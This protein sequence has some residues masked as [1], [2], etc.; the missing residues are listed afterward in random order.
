MYLPRNTIL[1][2]AI[3]VVAACGGGS[4]APKSTTPTGTLP[5]TVTVN[6]TPSI[7][8]APANTAIAVGGTV[9]FVFGSVAHTVF[10]DNDPAG[11]PAAIDGTNANSSVQRTFAVAG[12]YTFD[13][14]IHPGMSGSI[15]VGSA[16]DTTTRS[17]SGYTYGRRAPRAAGL[18]K[19]D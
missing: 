11:A 18:R 2:A 15:A 7:A 1:G 17:D 10:F 8:F 5:A 19:A 3:V 16:A 6:A 14:H 9:T 4:T 12:V 13:C